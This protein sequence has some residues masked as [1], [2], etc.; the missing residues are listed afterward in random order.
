[1]RWGKAVVVLGLV[2]LLSA[3]GA[4][5]NPL[6][7]NGDR[8]EPVIGWREC[9]HAKHDGITEVGLYEWDDSST[10]DEPGELLWH[11][12]ADR[13]LP[14]HRI[15]MGSAPEGFTTQRPLT[16]TLDARSTYALRT[17][18]TSDDLVPGFLTFR[19]EQLSTG[20]VV[21][22]DGRAESRREYEGLDS[23]QFGCFTS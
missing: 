10:V 15:R 5:L 20:R 22:S 6:F 2:F 17:N 11:I 4:E 12:K 19:P 23:E 7:I 16:A 14:L 18:M 13:S 3:C 8:A 9:P 1:M 21:F